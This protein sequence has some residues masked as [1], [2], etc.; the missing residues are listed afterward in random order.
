MKPSTVLASTPNDAYG[1]KC[2]PVAYV[3]NKDTDGATPV[4]KYDKCWFSAAADPT[5]IT[6]ADFAT[7]SA[8]LWGKVTGCIDKAGDGVGFAECEDDFTLWENPPTTGTC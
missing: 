7:A 4:V 5:Q 8:W 6:S 3:K 1:G 2:I